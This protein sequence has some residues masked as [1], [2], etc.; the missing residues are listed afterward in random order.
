MTV[1]IDATGHHAFMTAVGDEI[2]GKIFVREGVW[3]SDQA[4]VMAADNDFLFSDSKGNRVRGKRASFAGDDYQYGPFNPG[5]PMEGLVI[6]TMD[7]GYFYVT[8]DRGV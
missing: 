8:F 2:P 1:T 4:A 5:V 6:T 7:S 3:V